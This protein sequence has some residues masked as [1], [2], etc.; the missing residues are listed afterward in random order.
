MIVAST[1]TIN[2]LFGARFMVSGTGMI[3]N[4]YMFLFTPRPGLANSVQPGKR[5]TSSMSPLIVLRDGKPAFALGLPGGI[6]IFAAAMQGVI[7][8]IDHGMSLQE[9][10]EAPRLWTQGYTLEV[11]SGFG[12]D[13]DTGPARSGARCLG[14]RQRRERHVRYQLCAGR[15][16]D[17]CGVLAR[18][19][20]AD[21]TWRRAGAARRAF[22]AR[23]GVKMTD[24]ALRPAAS[25][26][27]AS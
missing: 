18:R 16:D 9:A 3:P 19:W 15:H 8:L 27:P 26:D 21:G 10:V 11:E 6:R 22:Q 1:Q 25:R 4:N 14:R 13:A 17:R 20:N 24:H 7:N 23:S 12:A 2:S 5:V